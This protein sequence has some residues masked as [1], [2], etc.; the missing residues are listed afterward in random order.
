MSLF[1]VINPKEFIKLTNT[2]KNARVIPVD[3]SWYMPNMKRDGKREFLD[4]ERLPGAVYFDIDGV[5]DKTSPF[6]HMLPDLETFNFEMGKLGLNETDVLVVYDKLGNF[7]SPRAAWTLATLGHKDVYLLNNWNKYTAN[8]DYPL[9]TTKLTEFS[10]YPETSYKSSNTH[11]NE[12]LL[13]YDDMKE[14]VVSGKLKELYNIYDAR[15]MGRY[16]GKD[17]E[18][19]PGMPSGHIPMVQPLPFTEVLDAQ[20]KEFYDPEQMKTKISTFFKENGV[21]FD[22][23]KPTVAMCGTGVTGVITKTALEQSG[24][25]KDPIKL[26]DG[27]WTEWVGRLDDSKGESQTLIA[28]GRE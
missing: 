23:S 13:S 14:L 4:T 26:Y 5:K 11:V 28:T 18:P 25:V 27:S 20:T 7:A 10:R 19:R 15:S 3:S 8:K 1:K 17:P 16:T 2:V 6:P 12:Q 22:P 21:S 9:E 24:L